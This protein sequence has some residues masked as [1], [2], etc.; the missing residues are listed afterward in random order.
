M[1]S[2]SKS[3]KLLYHLGGDISSSDSSE[4]ACPVQAN[5]MATSSSVEEQAT[6]D[7]LLAGAEAPGPERRGHS[8]M[9]RTFGRARDPRRGR[10]ARKEPS[11]DPPPQSAYLH[12]PTCGPL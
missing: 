8:T 6:R 9:P 4:S 7:A 3:A 10:S 1:Y 12:D 11:P 2:R 5:R